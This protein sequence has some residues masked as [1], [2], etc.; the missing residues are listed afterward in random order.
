MNKKIINKK[1][2]S[3]NISY[4]IYTGN[5][6]PH[7]NLKRLIEAIVKL[8][9]NGGEKVILKLVGSRNIFI[10]R[11]NKLINDLKANDF[12][13]ILGFI[14]DLELKNLYKNSVAFVF[15]TLAEGFGLPPMEA[16]E[17]LLRPR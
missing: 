15:P 6:Y 2:L 5:A 8:N 17:N 12:V 16:I 7:K 11:I 1:I 4:F 10:E 3:Q 14:S 9:R 13:E